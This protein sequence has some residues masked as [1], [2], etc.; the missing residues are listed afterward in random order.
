VQKKDPRGQRIAL[1]EVSSG[2]RRRWL[3]QSSLGSHAAEVRDKT[4]VQS[5]LSRAVGRRPVSISGATGSNG[6]VE[7]VLRGRA[8]PRARERFNRRLAL[9]TL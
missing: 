4:D 6:I 7:G 2:K 1:D 3:R 5:A 8:C 9:V